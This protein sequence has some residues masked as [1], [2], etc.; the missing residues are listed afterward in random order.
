MSDAVML[1]IL[2]AWGGATVGELLDFWPL[3]GSPDSYRVIQHVRL[4]GPLATPSVTSLTFLLHPVFQIKPCHSFI[5]GYCNTGCF[6]F[7]YFLNNSSH[8][9]NVSHFCHTLYQPF[10]WAFQSGLKISFNLILSQ[11]SVYLNFIFFLF[12][13]VSPYLC[14][15]FE[16]HFP[17]HSLYRDFP[18]GFHN[19][20]WF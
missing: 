19:P 6:I 13:C 18:A 1:S 9:V 2:G 14:C 15:S 3:G 8:R 5:Q 12:Q 17:T 16:K 7:S 11:F 20:S 4:D 10:H